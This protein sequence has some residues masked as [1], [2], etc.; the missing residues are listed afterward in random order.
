MPW[1]VA[2]WKSGRDEPLFIPSGK[3]GYEYEMELQLAGV[4]SLRGPIRTKKEAQEEALFAGSQYLRSLGR[5]RR[6]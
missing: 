4:T 2:R 3:L 6:R 5:R 1:Y